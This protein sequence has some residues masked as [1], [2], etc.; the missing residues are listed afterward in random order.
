MGRLPGLDRANVSAGRIHQ[1]LIAATI[2]IF[3]SIAALAYAVSHSLQTGLRL[4]AAEEGAALIDLV[5]GPLVQELATET[6]LSKG[7]SRKLDDLL[8]GK[9][10]DRIKRLE[11]WLRDGTLAYASG[12]RLADEKFPSHQV[13]EAFSGKATGTLNIPQGEG[14]LIEV[15]APLYFTGTKDIIAVGAIYNDGERLTTALNSTQIAA[16]AAT[17]AITAPVIFGLFFMVRRAGVTLGA[18]REALNAQAREAATLTGQNEKLQQAVDDARMEMVQSNERLLDRIGQ[19][20]HDGPI[21]LLGILG[22]KLTDPII[23]DSLSE[24]ASAT[25]ARDILERTLIDLRNVAAGLVLPELDGLTTEQTLRLAAS[26]H[27]KMT[28]TKVACEIDDLPSCPTPLR[29]CLYRMVQEA[30]NNA[31]HHANGNGQT[32][33][34]SADANWIGLAITDAGAG[35]VTTGRAPHSDTEHDRGLGLTGMRRRVELF[36]GTFEVTPGIDGGTRVS[37]KIPVIRE[38]KLRHDA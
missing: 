21:Q 2:A 18:Q 5:L 38:P 9:F 11:I 10:G 13:E 28:G 27:E 35:S 22:L 31:Y 1:F 7:S 36:H 30:L 16:V 15:F 23:A 20:L 33:I 34:A 19:D 12:S 37:A 4:T 17:A 14:R 24:D 32:V 26:Q 3:C 6:K 8:R 29:I 25:N